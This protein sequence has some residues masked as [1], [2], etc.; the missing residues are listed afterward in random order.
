M[1]L[2]PQ[3]VQEIDRE[4]VICVHDSREELI[5]QTTV[6]DRGTDT[7]API[8]VQKNLE[9]RRENTGTPR[10]TDGCVE[11]AIPILYDDRRC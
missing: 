11:R 5:M 8:Q 10:T 7:H 4:A 2:L 6:F 1:T 3:P 9:D